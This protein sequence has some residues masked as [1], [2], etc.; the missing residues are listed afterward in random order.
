MLMKDKVAIVTGA[1]SIKGIG[2]ATA[3][4]FAEEG[5]RVALIDLDAVAVQE[6]AKAIGPGHRGYSCDVRDAVQCQQVIQTIIA[7]FEYVDI[8]V[9]NAG[10]SQSKRLMDST[11]D[12]YDL[13]MDV[14]LRGAYNMSRALVP[15]LRLRK[16]GAIA[17]MGSVAAQR[18]GEGR[19]VDDRPQLRRVGAVVVRVEVRL[20]VTGVAGVQGPAPAA[21]ASQAERQRAGPELLAPSKEKPWL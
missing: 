6:A 1:A 13:V 3:K 8:L 20:D 11:M 19:A 16:S 9:N 4:R 21:A 2:W 5:A 12:D 18:G 10:V 14:S 15:H 7:D 17:C